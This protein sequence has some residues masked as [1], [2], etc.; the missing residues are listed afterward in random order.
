MIRR[1][2]ATLVLL[3]AGSVTA[4]AQATFVGGEVCATCHED[5]GKTFAKSPHRGVAKTCESCHGPG[6]KHAESLSAADIRNPAKLK[7]AQTDRVCLTC[8]LNQPT[9]IGRIQSSHAKNQV[10][11][12]A[13]H[14]MHKDKLVVRKQ[15]EINEQ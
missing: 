14:S 8:H 7:P 12:V 1:F 2:A 5:I 15:T 9:H 11:C 10:S 13:C 4:S 3:V 6:G